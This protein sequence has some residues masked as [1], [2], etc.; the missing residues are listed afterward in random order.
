MDLDRIKEKI[1]KADRSGR[2]A[3][4]EI[5]HIKKTLEGY[6]VKTIAQGKKKSKE[7]AQKITNLDSSIEK[8]K[9]ELENRL[10]AMEE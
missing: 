2:S 8:K 3:E 1:E 6:G 7:L 9:E 5:K 10:V 4:I